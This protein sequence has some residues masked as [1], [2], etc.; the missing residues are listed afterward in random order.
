[1]KDME[2]DS[3]PGNAWRM[4]WLWPRAGAGGDER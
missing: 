4:P 3:A 2:E 1:M